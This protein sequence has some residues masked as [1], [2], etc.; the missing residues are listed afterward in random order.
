MSDTYGY[1]RVSTLKQKIERQIANI[2]KEYPNAIIIDEAYTGT[3]MD[4]PKCNKL[5]KGL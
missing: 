1:A 2:K 3:S 4:R 5:V